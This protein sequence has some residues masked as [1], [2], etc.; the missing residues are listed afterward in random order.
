[1][2]LANVASMTSEQ[3]SNPR[4]KILDH[5]V[6]IGILLPANHAADLIE[7]AK[8]RRES[9]GQMLRKLIDRELASS[10]CSG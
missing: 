6:E 9:V 10:R 3:Y 8:G 7:M 1:M 4:S 2:K 5:V